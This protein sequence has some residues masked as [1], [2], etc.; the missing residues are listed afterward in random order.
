MLF[1]YENESDFIIEFPDSNLEVAIREKI[2]KYFGDVYKSEVEN[3]KELDTSEAN[4]Q[5]IEEVQH[6]QVLRI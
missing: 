6:Y 4:I 5:S 1:T 3:I 2:N